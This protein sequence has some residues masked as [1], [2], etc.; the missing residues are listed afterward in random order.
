MSDR[1]PH[2][3]PIGDAGGAEDR[4]DVLATLLTL[5]G[6][7]AD[8]DDA[9]RERVYSQVRDEWRQVTDGGQ[10]RPNKKWRSGKFWALPVALAAA[11]V[12]AI[13]A[14]Q[15]PQPVTIVRP[16]GSIALLTD[17][18]VQKGYSLGQPVM[19]GDVLDT[20]GG[21]GL[22][23]SLD[24]ETSLRLDGGSLLT[25]DAGDEFTLISGRVYIDTGPAMYGKTPL[26]VHTASGT[27][28][29]IG[30]QFSVAFDAVDMTVAVREGEVNVSSLAV[31]HKVPSGDR[32]RVR[33]GAPVSRES[34]SATDSSWGWAVALAPM[35]NVDQRSFLDFLKWVAR[36]TGLE[37]QFA[38]DELRM[39]TMQVELNGTFDG[40]SIE[41]A[42]ESSFQ[43]TNL[44]YSIDNGTLTVMR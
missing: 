30:T 18:L 7:R 15:A 32:L 41:G 40:M 2:D 35:P 23:L 3:S 19:A 8:V 16:I 13:V 27:A 34:I 12:L 4:D 9:M 37:L 25:V 33:P 24:R 28:V 31:T 42:I 11:F 10:R 6:P 36:E 43:T 14:V 38:D 5:P 39:L 21:G 26:N 29:D 1:K 17:D 22:S 44:S 20:L